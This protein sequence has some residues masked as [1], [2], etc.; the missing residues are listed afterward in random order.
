MI[1]RL[2]STLGLKSS[3][4]A[5]SFRPVVV[6]G[7]S[8]G[9]KSTILTRLFKENPNVFA[10]SVSHTTRH[11]RPGEINGKDYYFVEK[12]TMQK[13]IANGE[14]LEHASFGG[15]LY[16]TSMKAVKDIQATGKICILDIELQ[17][18]R[19]VKKTDLNARYVFVKPP[20]MEDLEKRL[21]ARNT[22]TEESLQKRLSQANID[23]EAVSKEP[24]LFDHVIINDDLDKAYQEFFKIVENDI[25]KL[26]ES[27]KTE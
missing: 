19:S 2:L 9:G 25:K 23:T 12:D 3:P 20:S 18:V 5:M 11:P 15:N 7:P 14:F 16:G 21:R 27:T 22:E 24:K 17:G 26:K 6:S 10:F 1:S 13:S 8:G 4:L